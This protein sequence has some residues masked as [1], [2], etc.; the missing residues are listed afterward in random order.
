MKDV[1]KTP[2]IKPKKKIIRPHIFVKPTSLNSKELRKKLFLSLSDDKK[3]KIK[4]I[5]KKLYGHRISKEC[6]RYKTVQKLVE[7]RE[8]RNIK[9]A[10]DILKYQLKQLSTLAEFKKEKSVTE[11]N[12]YKK[13]EHVLSTLFL[14]KGEP[15]WYKMF[16]S[17]G[18]SPVII[19]SDLH[20]AGWYYVAKKEIPDIWKHCLLN[21]LGIFSEEE[22]KKVVGIIGEFTRYRNL[23]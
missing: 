1:I 18:H 7:I 20:N 2:E 11:Y 8:S 23:Y 16:E 13:L 9:K 10:A 14:E 4:E 21:D 3:D 6:I 17:S 12:F 15:Y 19:L 5:C 22:N